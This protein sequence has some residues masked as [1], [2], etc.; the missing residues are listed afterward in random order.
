MNHLNL[1]IIGPPGSGKTSAGKLLAE[2][3]GWQFIDTDREI[4]AEHDLTVSQIFST[5]GEEY[6][7]QLETHLLEKLAAD[8]QECRSCIIATGGGIAT[9]VGNF[10]KLEKIGLVVCLMAPAECLAVRLHE[11]STRP[12]LAGPPVGCENPLNKKKE[13]L[14]RL[15]ASRKNSYLQARYTIETAG[16]TP[17]EVAG[18]LEKLISVSDQK[19]NK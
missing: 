14:E 3:L 15:L 4:E 10:Q 2:R 18:E 9:T 8:R 16:R 17:E 5:H 13:T 11:D 7:R 12:L 1:V 6:F 19:R